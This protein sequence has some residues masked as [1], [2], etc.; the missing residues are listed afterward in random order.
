MDVLKNKFCH[1][2][3]VVC[4]TETKE[5]LDYD[6]AIIIDFPVYFLDNTSL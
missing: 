6:R 5:M 2:F 1:A 3:I 4:K